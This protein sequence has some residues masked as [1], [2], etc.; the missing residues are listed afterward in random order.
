[1]PTEEEDREINAGIAADPDTYE[2][3][4]EEISNLKPFRPGRPK[5]KNPKVPVTVRLD[6]EVVAFFRSGGQGWQTRLNAVLSNYVGRQR[7]RV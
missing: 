3:S 7:R 2:L 6:P 1:M 5:L 4:D